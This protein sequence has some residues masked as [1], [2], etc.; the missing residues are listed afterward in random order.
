M[1][2]MEQRQ[3]EM[4]PRESSDNNFTRTDG[5]NNRQIQATWANNRTRTGQEQ[6][7]DEQGRTRHSR[8]N[9]KQETQDMELHKQ[10]FMLSC[11]SILW[12]TGDSGRWKILILHFSRPISGPI[13]NLDNIFQD[14]IIL[15]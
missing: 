3:M 4:E 15:I 5:K 13:A 2:Q 8:K 11:W 14:S 10:Y 7:E 12:S 1:E 6:Q 9:K